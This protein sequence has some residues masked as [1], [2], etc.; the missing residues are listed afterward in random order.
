MLSLDLVLAT[1][2]MRFTICIE[3]DTKYTIEKIGHWLGVSMAIW[4]QQRL[5]KKNV[6]I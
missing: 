4:G 1:L 2:H 3:Q 5:I 6:V